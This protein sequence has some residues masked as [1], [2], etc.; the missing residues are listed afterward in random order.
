MRYKFL[1]LV[2]SLV[3]FRV[4]MTSFNENKN[5]KACSTDVMVALVAP[6]LLFDFACWLFFDLINCL[7]NL[8]LIFIECLIP[9]V[10]KV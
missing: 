9:L 6:G 7:Y 1:S 4:L 5:K 2:L 8:F 10:I 3:F